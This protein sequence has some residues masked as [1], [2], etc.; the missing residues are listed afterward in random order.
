MIEGAVAGKLRLHG[1]RN[2]HR[3]E[4]E[5]KPGINVII[6]D[7]GRGKTNLLE[8]LFF[9]LQGK[10]MRTSDATEMI[11]RGESEAIVEGT[12]FA[13]GETKIKKAITAE[14]ISSP[15]KMEK[16][17]QAVSFQPDDIWIVKGGPEARR[18]CLDEAVLDTRKAYR[19][20]MREYQRVLRQR[21]EAIRAVRKGSKGRESIRYWNPLLYRRGSEIV[22]ERTRKARTLQEGMDWLSEKW[23]KEGIVLRY[24]TSLGDAVDDEGKTLEKIEKMEESEIRRGASLVGPH[25]DEMVFS[26]GG[27]NVRRECSQGEQKMVTIMWKLAQAK[28]VGDTTGRK[29]LLLMDDCLSE[30]DGENRA[31]LMRELEEWEQVIATSTDDMPEFSGA[32]RIL[33]EKEEGA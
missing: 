15:R 22:L 32:H 26:L 8:A 21:N 12:F 13:A 29:I 28:A 5:F 1:F 3:M 24:Y 20:T 33:L 4:L 9:L 27:R 11:R 10:S 14:G 17:I 25:R 2:Y 30:L 6:G 19:E 23:G 31:L 7:N 18:R 16:E